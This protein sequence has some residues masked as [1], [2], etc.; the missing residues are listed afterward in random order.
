MASTEIKEAL[1]NVANEVAQY[2][3][4]AST[5]TVET[6][7]VQVGGGAPTLAAKTV[8]KI[9]G[10]NTTVLPTFKN[11]EGKMEV[12]AVMYDLHMQNV[13]AAIDYR[14]KILDALIDVLLP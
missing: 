8:I 2:V 14:S 1:K 10:D 6:Q 11:A 13:Q 12:D 9:D 7:T 3:K 4:D 5:L